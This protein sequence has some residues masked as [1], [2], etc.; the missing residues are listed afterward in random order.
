MRDPYQV[1]GVG[2]TASADEIKSAY[3]KLARA[4]HPDVNPNNPR[5]E[6]QFKEATSAYDLLSDPVKRRRFDRG[7]INAEGQERAR[8]GGAR[9]GGRGTRPGAGATGGGGSRSWNFDSMF[10]DDDLF[11]DIFA[12]ASKGPGGRQHSAPRKG[13]DVNY[14]LHVTFE[15]AALG[16][17]RMVSLTNGKRLTVKVPPG[18]EDGAVLR[19]KGQ[20]GPGQSGGPDGDALVEVK[21]KPHALLRREGA[22]VI[23]EVPVTLHEAVL[24]ARIEVPTISGKVRLKV[25]AGSNGGTTLRLPAKGIPGP[26]GTPGD[27]LVRLRLVLENP[28]DGRLETFLKKWTPD[29]PNPRAKLGLD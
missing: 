26:D 4:M 6:E 23:A 10:S 13:P 3:R 25:P 17:S 22:V 5:A 11:S 24:G 18:T 1:L 14:R 27:Q 20:G 2:R 19:L 7:E 9:P 8:S 21:V 15:E 28:T 29:G 16:T 12:R